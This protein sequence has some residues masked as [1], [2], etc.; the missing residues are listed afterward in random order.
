MITTQFWPSPFAKI[1]VLF[2]PQ[3]SFFIFQAAGIHTVHGTRRDISYLNHTVDGYKHYIVEYKQT[4]RSHRCI[5]GW[6]T[7]RPDEPHHECKRWIVNRLGSTWGFAFTVSISGMHSK[8][9]FHGLE[10]KGAQERPSMELNR[11]FMAVPAC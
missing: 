10:W 2:K 3:L 11:I 1:F 8:W 6:R 4:R 9:R 5:M 7:F